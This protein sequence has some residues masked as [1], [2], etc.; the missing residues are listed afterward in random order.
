MHTTQ[1]LRLDRHR[2][3]GRG[4]LHRQLHR[5]MK[6]AAFTGLAFQ[7]DF[8][9][10]QLH[11]PGANGQAQPGAAIFPRHGLVGLRER[12]KNPGLLFQRDADAGILD[13]EM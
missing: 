1:F 5:E 8:S 10:H 6:S 3:D 12:L 9:V 13:C 7:P 4:V 2:G 11:Q